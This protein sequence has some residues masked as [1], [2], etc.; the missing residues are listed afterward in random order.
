ME[1][2]RIEQFFSTQEHFDNGYGYTNDSAQGDGYGY[3][4]DYGY[5]NGYGCISGYGTTK[6]DGE[7]RGHSHGQGYFEGDGHG[8]ETLFGFG[9]IASFCGQ[10]VYDI[11]RVSTIIQSVHGNYAK[12]FILNSDFTFKKTYIAKGYGYFA[13]GS[14]LRAAFKALQ[15]KIESNMSIEEKQEEFKQKFNKSDSYSGEEFFEW[16]HL[17]TGSCLQGREA[18]VKTKGLDLKA[19]YTVKDF[20]KIVEGAYGW[21]SIKDLKEFYD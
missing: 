11:D 17:L 4:N 21:N 12:G 1:T 15:D 6:G 20:L 3:T 16:H 13:H 18:F 10:K 7:G 5:T 14:T 8:F 2:S 9:G 19:K